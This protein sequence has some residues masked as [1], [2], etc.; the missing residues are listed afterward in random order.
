MSDSAFPAGAYPGLTTKELE[1]A[2]NKAYDEAKGANTLGF[3]KWSAMYA[4]LKRREA[5]EAGDWSQATPG[6]RLRAVK[7]GKLDNFEEWRT[8]RGKG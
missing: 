4:E 3:N 6:E 2:C 5:V 8:G 7:E 1:Q